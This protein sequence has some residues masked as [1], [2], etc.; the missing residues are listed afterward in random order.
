VARRFYLWWVTKKRVSLAMIVFL[1]VLAAGLALTG[2][3]SVLVPVSD[4]VKGKVIVIDP[5]HGGEDP[6][7][8]AGDLLEKDIN[9]DVAQRLENNLAKTGA[10][11]VMTRR[12]DN[13]FTSPGV[14]D[15]KA[16]Q[17]NDLD[18]RLAIAEENEADLFIS[19]HANKGRRKGAYGMETYYH[20]RSGKGQAL[21]EAIQRELG[22]VQK[23][24]KRKAKAG[25]YYLLRNTEMPAV[26]V[27]VGFLSNS[28]ERKLLQDDMYKDRIAEAIT[29]GVL[30]FARSGGFNLKTDQKEKPAGGTG[31]AGGFRAEKVRIYFPK[32]TTDGDEVLATELKAPPRV[33]ALA[34]SKDNTEA[35]ARWALSELLAGPAGGE[36]GFYPVF[37]PGTRI[38]GLEVSRGTAHVDLS[39][40]V[41]SGFKGSAGEEQLLVASVVNTLTQLNGIERV[42]ITVAGKTEDTLNGHVTINQPLTA[43]Q[44][45]KRARIAIVIDD[46]GGDVPG[47]KEMFKLD[48]PLTFAVMPHLEFSRQQAERAK[49]EGFQ[50][51]LHLPMEPTQGKASWLG[52]GAITTRMSDEEIRESVREDLAEI[53]WAVGL[54]N[55]MGSRATADERVMRAVLGVAREKHLF[56]LDS[57][58]TDKTVIPVVASELK[59]P[60]TQRTVF[61][62]NVNSLAHI[63]KQFDKVAEE[64]LAKGEAVAIG[65]VGPTGPK[66]VKV[67]E[68]MLPKLEDEGIELV[69]VS[70]LVSK[71]V[72][73]K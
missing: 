12:G 16:R 67:L 47:V 62:D 60:M 1:V 69:Y 7:A 15:R 19:I 49:K 6:G 37:P 46:F 18:G 61:L 50:V 28:R 8:V 26:I 54:N 57:R 11:V 22:K 48:Y 13:N 2:T 71:R 3:I 29:A 4:S 52:P 63:R 66:M 36:R 17:R 42:K 31:S 53:P 34:G 14:G 5:G 65:H 40:E 24:N 38:L 25:N 51:I 20:A 35:V 59:V 70:E 45:G 41:Q 43:A 10:K 44:A 73:G 27:E 30:E 21:A 72:S 56:V 33:T 55:H 9:L 68:E 39:R 64:A 23:D 58:T 32:I